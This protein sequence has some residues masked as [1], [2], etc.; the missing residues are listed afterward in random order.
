MP[1][2]GQNSGSEA[3]S[4]EVAGLSCSH[5]NCSFSGSVRVLVEVIMNLDD[6]NRA[7]KRWSQTM[8]KLENPSRFL[9][10]R[11]LRTE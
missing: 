9:E 10:Q 6:N 8:A 11:T 1:K 3:S 7:I 2:R 4:I 5:S